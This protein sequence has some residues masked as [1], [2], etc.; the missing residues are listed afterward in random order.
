[1]MAPV[2][3]LDSLNASVNKPK[4]DIPKS[5]KLA[6]NL[7][8]DAGINALGKKIKN[9]KGLSKLEGYEQH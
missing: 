6:P 8:V 3:F 9:K 7:P 1:M 5:E 2:N 4:K